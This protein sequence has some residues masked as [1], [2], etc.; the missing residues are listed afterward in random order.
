M[1]RSI[2]VFIHFS[3]VAWT[4]L[5][6]MSA[7]AG[8]WQHDMDLN[9]NNKTVETGGQ[10]YTIKGWLYKMQTREFIVYVE[11][12]DKWLFSYASNPLFPQPAAAVVLAADNI[13]SDNKMPAPAPKM[14]IFKEGPRELFKLDPNK[15]LETIKDIQMLPK[16]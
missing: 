1:K 12:G 10:K 7:R 16:K 9:L 13:L 6:V 3:L 11:E 2:R 4:M 14:Y 15:L 5:V 8:S